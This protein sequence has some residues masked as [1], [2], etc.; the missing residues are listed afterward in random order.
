MVFHAFSP[1]WTIQNPIIAAARGNSAGIDKP[2]KI[3]YPARKV[4]TK[5][6]IKIRV[7]MLC[8]LKILRD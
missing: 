7:S 6:K 5:E 4:K 8:G 3:K 1:W 2:I